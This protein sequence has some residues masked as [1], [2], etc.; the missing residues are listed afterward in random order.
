[1]TTEK[2]DYER[3]IVTVD[4]VVL[5]LRD[6]KLHVLL[7]KRKEDSPYAPGRWSL[8][9]GFIHTDEDRSDEDAVRRVLEVKAGASARHVEQLQTFASASRDSRGWSVSI[10]YL[11][12]VDTLIEDEDSVRYFPVDNMPDLPFDHNKIVEVAM[13]RVRNKAAYSSLP[14]FFLPKTFTLPQMQS[15][16]EIVLGQKLNTPAFRRKVMEQGL[17]EEVGYDNSEDREPQKGRPAAMYTL[18][19][20]NLQNLGRTVMTPDTRRGGPR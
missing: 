16:Y 4:A 1:M 12:I 6:Q 20:I 18:A 14:T 5:A 11:A 17:V 13:E 7:A 2:Q 10:S 8:P 9:G 15:V 19:N 3:P